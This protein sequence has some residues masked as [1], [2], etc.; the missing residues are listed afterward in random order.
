M[1][2]VFSIDIYALLYTSVILSFLISL[3][4]GKFDVLPDV[5]IEFFMVTTL[6]GDSVV[7]RR[8]FR[9]GP[10]SFPNRVTWVDFVALDMVDFCHFENGLVACL[11]CFH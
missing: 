3:V 1:L 6:V 11:F 5:L 9:S 7:S 4:A 10:I 2:Q 8:V